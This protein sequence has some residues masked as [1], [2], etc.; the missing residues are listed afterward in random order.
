MF[1][2]DLGVGWARLYRA[3]RRGGGG[4]RRTNEA[5]INYCRERHKFG[6]PI[7]TFQGLQRMMATR[8]QAARHLVYHTAWRKDSG[9]RYSMETAMAKVHA[10]E[11]AMWTTTKAVQIHG[12]MKILSCCSGE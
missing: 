4:F 11:A 1:R 8:V 3:D 2:E 12:G 6:R 10:P 7:S 5:S 9:A